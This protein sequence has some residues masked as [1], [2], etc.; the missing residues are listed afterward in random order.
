MAKK[1]KAEDVSIEKVPQTESGSG[2]TPEIKKKEKAEKKKS[3][4]KP[5]KSQKYFL[6]E[7]DPTN[8]DLT[9]KEKAALAGC[10]ISLAESLR[11][12][13]EFRSDLR[14]ARMMGASDFLSLVDLKLLDINQN[15]SNE[16]AQVSAA[17]EIY[18]RWDPEYVEKKEHSHK[19][20][21]LDVIR[22]VYGS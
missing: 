13:T 8:N 5:G 12:N 15:G 4:E 18:K 14:E 19:V 10:S 9:V 11:R 17:R 22:D 2:L 7:C 16:Q 21:F 3:W 1:I 6:V 20:T